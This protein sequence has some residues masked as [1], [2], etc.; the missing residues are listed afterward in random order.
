MNDIKKSLLE[1][2]A[3]NAFQNRDVHLANAL[4]NEADKDVVIKKASAEDVLD[5]F[6]KSR[7][8]YSKGRKRNVKF[9]S[10]SQREQ[11]GL[12]K[13]M[14]KQIDGAL[15]GLIQSFLSTIK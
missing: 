3:E 9:D 6:L 14:E 7:K 4:Y 13:R 1:F 5:K 10:M 15:D 8:W 11:T 2:A 12:R